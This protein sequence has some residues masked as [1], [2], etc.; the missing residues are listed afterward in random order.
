MG[1]LVVP[2]G[3]MSLS[4]GCILNNTLRASRRLRQYRPNCGPR[5]T[6]HELRLIKIT[7][8]MSA[9]FLLAWLPYSI[10]SMVSA[11]VSG[12]HVSG[13]N[14]VL[15]TLLAKV[16]HIS[17]PLVYFTLNP[18]LRQRVPCCPGT[19]LKIWTTDCSSDSGDHANVALEF[20]TL[21]QA[22]P[23]TQPV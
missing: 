14:S 11:Y 21:P 20:A 2:L 7:L 5:R 9:C 1:C 23:T 12:L 13:L 8:L 4:Y 22:S 17:N 3:V 19:I 10:V 18:R 15:P 6:R 16:S